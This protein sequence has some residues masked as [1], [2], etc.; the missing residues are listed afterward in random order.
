MNVI[1]RLE[2]ELA[3]KEVSVQNARHYA[4]ETSPGLFQIYLDSFGKA[5]VYLGIYV[6]IAFYKI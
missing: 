2:F 6:S 1:A 4:K 3:Y 5:F